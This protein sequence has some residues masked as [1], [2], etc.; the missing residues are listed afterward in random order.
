M[1]NGRFFLSLTVHPPPRRCCGFTTEEEDDDIDDDFTI[2]A[3]VVDRA[4]RLVASRR[5]SAA[6]W[7][8][9]GTTTTILPCFCVAF[10]AHWFWEVWYV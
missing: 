5:A 4:S 1:T 9:F 6:R 10:L 3:A 8:R 7:V 2:V